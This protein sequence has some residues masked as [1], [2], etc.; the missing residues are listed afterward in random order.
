MSMVEPV[1]AAIS[2]TERHNIAAPSTDD[3]PTPT[4]GPVPGVHSS[5]QANADLLPL[6]RLH[7]GREEEDV[8]PESTK[9]SNL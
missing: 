6:D 1:R 8:E 2:S 5:L 4:L 3:Y 7:N 9:F